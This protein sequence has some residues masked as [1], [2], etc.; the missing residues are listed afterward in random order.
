MWEFSHVIRN[1]LQKYFEKVNIKF[2]TVVIK[3]GGSLFGPVMN[4]YK[5]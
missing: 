4:M 1:L 2:A 3:F 5:V